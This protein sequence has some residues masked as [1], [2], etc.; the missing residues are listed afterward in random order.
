MNSNWI[1]VAA[2]AFGTVVQ[3]D[4]IQLKNGTRV[5]GR[6]LAENEDGLEI[7]VG[8]NEA[9]TI[10]RVLII[11]SS[12]I[13]TWAADQEGRIAK[14]ERKTVNRLA[15]KDYVKRLL[16]EAERK[17]D[18]RQFDQGIEEFQQ[19]AEISTQNL[20]QLEGIE[21]VDALNLR[22]HALRLALAALEGKVELI[23]NQTEGVKDELEDRK[24]KWEK[25]WKQ[26]QDEIRDYYQRREGT[27][28]V[29]LGSKRGKNDFVEREKDL[30][31]EKGSIDHAIRTVGVQVEELERMKVEVEAKIKLV[32]ERIDQAED[33][34]KDAQREARSRR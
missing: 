7:E 14:A 19:A 20:D 15:G 22:A 24:D 28:R 2:I 12:E 27:R 3:A 4:Y 10:R 26:L 17:I 8:A 34:A 13:A 1:W 32:E 11:H 23:D 29:E 33:E 16:A 31:L 21:K 30:R 25:D 6:I 18:L 9:G 5:D